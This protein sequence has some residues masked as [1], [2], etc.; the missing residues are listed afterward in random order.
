MTWNELEYHI[1]NMPEKRKEDKVIF[2]DCFNENEWE[3][4]NMDQ[5]SP[6][7]LIMDPFTGHS[8]EDDK[9]DPGAVYVLT[10]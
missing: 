6:H 1:A 8:L 4:D 2:R 9:D 3:I 7:D 5:V 10:D